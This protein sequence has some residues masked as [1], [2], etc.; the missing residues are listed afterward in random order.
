MFGLLQRLGRIPD[1][2]MYR[3]F[4]MGI[5]FA[6]VVSPED[7]DAARA[8]LEEADLRVHLLGHA[9]ADAARTIRFRPK[10]LVG[11]SGRFTRA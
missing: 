3:A 9:T 11:R 4:N 1:E 2:E 5:G 6:L 8:L 7:A 10:R